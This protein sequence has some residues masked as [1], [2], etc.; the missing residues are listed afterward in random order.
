MLDF[1]FSKFAYAVTICTNQNLSR[2][3]WIGVSVIVLGAGFMAM[4]GFGSRTKY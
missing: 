2:E 4:R 3:Q 1:I